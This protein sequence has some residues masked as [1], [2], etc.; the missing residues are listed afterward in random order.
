MTLD[1]VS[2]SMGCSSQT[3]LCRIETAH[4]LFKLD[5][6]FK[7]CEIYDVDPVILFKEIVEEAKDKKA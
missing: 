1:Y 7:L 5:T 6:Y 3:N 2:K 4:H